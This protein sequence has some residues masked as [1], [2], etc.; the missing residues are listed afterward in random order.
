MYHQV[1]LKHGY[2]LLNSEKKLKIAS[3]TIDDP[4]VF[5]HVPLY[6]LIVIIVNIC[7]AQYLTEPYDPC[8]YA[9]EYQDVEVDYVEKSVALLSNDVP[10]H[11]MEYHEKQYCIKGEHNIDADLKYRVYFLDSTLTRHSVLIS[12]SQE[13]FNI[14]NI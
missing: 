8:N 14:N 7:D 3:N 9:K 2:D 11:V 1:Q 10:D 6:I 13:L 5:L 12:H 4:N